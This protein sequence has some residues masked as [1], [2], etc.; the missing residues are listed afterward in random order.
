MAGGTLKNR[1]KRNQVYLTSS[2][3]NSPNIASPKYTITQQK[4]YMDP[5]SLLM[6][7]MGDFTKEINNS[8]KKITGKNR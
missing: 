6:M 2:E 3:T 1:S 4:Q 8:L 7:M 5:N